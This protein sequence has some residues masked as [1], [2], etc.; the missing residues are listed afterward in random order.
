MYI[1]IS[2]P[3]TKKALFEA[4]RKHGCEIILICSHPGPDGNTVEVFGHEP[5]TRVCSTVF[6]F[7]PDIIEASLSKGRS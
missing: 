1:R 7:G 4:A 3:E 6:L 2:D 5:H